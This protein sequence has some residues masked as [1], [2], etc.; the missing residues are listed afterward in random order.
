MYHKQEYQHASVAKSTPM[1]F[2]KN[3][4][5][6]GP[7]GVACFRYASRSPISTIREEL[8]LSVLQKETND[9]S[10]GPGAYSIPRLPIGPSC[11][12]GYQI[13]FKLKQN[14]TL[15]SNKSTERI[16]ENKNTSKYSPINRSTL[17]KKKFEK[18]HLLQ[19]INKEAKSI[20]ETDRKERL[21]QEIQEK[22]HK[23][24]IRK[25][26]TI[27]SNICKS[28]VTLM[29][30]LMA[31]KTAKSKFDKESAYRNKINHTISVF[32]IVCRALAKFRF[33]HRAV[34]IKLAW[35]VFKKYLPEMIK[36]KKKV[37]ISN[38]QERVAYFVDFFT[39][40]GS[41]FR[42]NLVLN[43]KVTLLQEYFRAFLQIIKCRKRALMKFWSKYDNNKE[44]IPEDKKLFYV[45]KYLKERMKSYLDHKK[46]YRENFLFLT[47]PTYH[48]NFHGNLDL[49][50]P[51]LRIFSKKGIKKLIFSAYINRDAWKLIKENNFSN[52]T[53]ILS[54]SQTPQPLIVKQ[55]KPQTNIKLQ[56]A[57][58]Y[59]DSVR[60]PGIKRK[61]VRIKTGAIVFNR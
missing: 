29:T 2:T 25:H 56:Q 31:I 3:F 39:K 1:L 17:L 15:S 55:P 46:K 53:P 28:Y 36:K 14:P 6:P 24:E 32:G 19:A 49:D 23:I 21:I 57:L 10:V 38:L 13:R 16:R 44:L 54:N 59:G 22:E 50:V 58:K 61:T 43:Q 18:L 48:E 8:N 42:M 11:S 7:G 12:F 51:N 52:Q 30:V 37:I 4:F 40:S 60:N 35:K 26:K 41:I 33:S 47:A 5:N 9:S 34:K 27:R 20:I 45:G